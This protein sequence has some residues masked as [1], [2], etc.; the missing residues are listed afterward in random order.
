MHI[1]C[2]VKCHDVLEAGQAAEHRENGAKFPKKILAHAFCVAVVVLPTAIGKDGYEHFHLETE[3]APLVEKN[4][5]PS[6]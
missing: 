2:D 5:N 3:T 6:G 4:E 1:N